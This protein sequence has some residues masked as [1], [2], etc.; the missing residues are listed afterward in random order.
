MKHIRNKFTALDM[1]FA[2]SERLHEK[3]LLSASHRIDDGG[4]HE[5]LYRHRRNISEKQA[6]NI[7]SRIVDDEHITYS[8]NKRKRWVELQ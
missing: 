1:N 8:L 3:L 4:L 6:R 7:H 2:D 5:G